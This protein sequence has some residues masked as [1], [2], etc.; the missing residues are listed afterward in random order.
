MHDYYQQTGLYRAR[1]LNRVLGDPRE[2]VVGEPTDVLA[3][4]RRAAAP[5]RSPIMFQDRHTHDGCGENQSERSVV[6]FG[7]VQRDHRGT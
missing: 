3:S 5:S 7:V 1:D 6:A 4:G 2:Q